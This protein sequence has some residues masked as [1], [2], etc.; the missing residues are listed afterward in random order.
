MLT[1]SLTGRTAHVRIP[2]VSDT[3]REGQLRVDLTRPL[4]PRGMSGIFAHSG[5]TPGRCDAVDISPT[6]Q[7]R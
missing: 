4:F 5:L 2:S 3:K 7:C 6:A 1:S